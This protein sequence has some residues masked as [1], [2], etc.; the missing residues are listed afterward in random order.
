MNKLIK[1]NYSFCPGKTAPVETIQFV[2]VTHYDVNI[3][4]G[5]AKNI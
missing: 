5:L 1:E 3:T 4:S 2:P